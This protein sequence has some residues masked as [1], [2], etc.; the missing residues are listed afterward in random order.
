MKFLHFPSRNLVIP[1]LLLLFSIFA[2]NLSAQVQY[3]VTSNTDAGNPQGLNGDRDDRTNGWTLIISGPQSSNSWSTAVSLPFGF[4]VYGQ[5][6]TQCRA[7]QNGLLTFNTGSIGTPPGNNTSLPNALLPDLTLAV[8]WDDFTVSPPTTSQSDIYWRTYGTAPNR[9]F[10]VKWDRFEYSN[11]TWAYFAVVLEESSNKIYFLDYNYNDGGP[12][13]STIGVQLDAATAVQAGASPNYALNSGTRN[14]G[15]NDYFEFVPIAAPVSIPYSEDFSSCTWPSEWWQSS[16]G[17]TYR[18]T[19]SNSNNA[20]GAACE[21]RADDEPGTGNGSSILVMPPFN[22]TGVTQLEVLFN[23]FFDDQGSGMTFGLASSGDLVTWTPEWTA[24]SGGGDLGPEPISAIVTNNLGSVTYLAFFLQGNM[25]ND[26]NSWNIDDVVVQEYQPCLTIPY[27][28]DFDASPAWP[29]G[30]VTTDPSIWYIDTNW[31]GVAPPTGN[32]VYS[33]Y[34][35][36]GTGTV[37]SP[38]FDGSLN[39]NIH[40]RF[41]HYWRADWP[42]STQDGYFYGSPDGG[43]TVYLIDEWH[44][45]T[46]GSDEGW[47]EYDVSAWADGGSNILFAWVVDHNDDW[48]WIF[49][50]FQIQEGP[51][52]TP[53]LWTG[54]VN[55]DWSNTGNWSDLTIPT[56]T[57]DVVIPAGCPN[58]PVVD[59]TAHV[60]SIYIMDGAD[61]TVT[62]GADLTL[63]FNIVTGLSTGATLTIDDGVVNAVI[64]FV[65]DGSYGQLNG[66]SLNLS[67]DLYVGFGIGGEFELNGG[68]CSVT[69]N[70]YTTFNSTTD[71]N[72]GNLSFNNWY[73]S[74]SQVFSRG[75]VEISGGLI[76][77]AGSVAFG[78]FDFTGVMDGPAEMIIGGTYR[79]LETNWTHTNGTIYMTGTSG[80]GPHYFMSSVFGAGNNGSAYNLGILGEGLEFRSNPTG[81]ITGFRVFNNMSVFGGLVSTLADPGYMND[82]FI[83]NGHANVRPKGSMTMSVTGT[84]TIG[85]NLLIWSNDQGTG[86]W[87]DNGNTSVSGVTTVQRYITPDQWHY[88][89]PPV[90]NAVSGV[91][92][93]SYLRAWEEPNYSWGPYI[94]PTNIPLNVAEGYELWK[95]GTP[96]TFNYTGGIL[97]TGN[98]AA[99]VTATDRNNNGGIYWGDYEGWNFIGNPY[100]SALDWNGSWVSSNIDPTVYIWD[101]DIGQ[102]AEWNWFTGL[103]VNKTDGIVPANQGFFVKANDFNPSIVIPQSQRL[104][105]TMDF[106]KN[107][108]IPSGKPLEAGIQDSPDEMV[109]RSYGVIPVKVNKPGPELSIENATEEI[110]GESQL[111]GG[112][113]F[114]N[115]LRLSVSGNGYTDEAIVMF[116]IDAT[117]SFDNMFDAFKLT[118]ISAAPQ[119]YSY[120][121]GEKMAMNCFPLVSGVKIVPLGLTVGAD[122]TYTLSAADIDSFIEGYHIYLEDTWAG[123]LINLKYQPV[124]Q[125]F[126]S[127]FDGPDRFRLHFAF[128]DVPSQE[129]FKGTGQDNTLSVYS[130]GNSIYVKTGNEFRGTLYVYNMMG[131]EIMHQAVEGAFSKFEVQAGEGAYI[132][133]LVG[134]GIINTSK[135]YFE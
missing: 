11:Y 49:D 99:N 38:C 63:N 43:T 30:W 81:N 62:T 103:G 32:H 40:V 109:A 78:G 2:L 29:A 75:N 74:P 85:G 111:K 13:T 3:A 118:G 15:D 42:F 113:F 107:S 128:E 52:G 21:M 84:S 122:A 76:N 61:F 106:Y 121:S 34:L 47:K 80:A 68:V 79:N 12:G 28:Q 126:A 60:N 18:W 110:A 41:Y 17:C 51:W 130:Y 53:G 70:L 129:E 23:H 132:V 1:V 72:S 86:S 87:I 67:G 104:H 115:H 125:F 88:V 5:A 37:Y 119:L 69:G 135:V 58:Y 48:Y 9:Q 16:V 112:T 36:V 82:N 97:N 131:Q 108:I 71:I 39:S 93:G 50:D 133:K 100:P 92:L 127:P 22:T 6:V 114:P 33:D 46:P 89:S 95:T 14:V 8:F 31:P 54:L 7:S 124:Y 64:L 90:S 73:R 59:E 134:S 98:I 56:S 102:Y 57:I 65:L 101:G 25:N 44:H 117:D 120:I 123:Q 20:G 66:G 10:W 77:A 83:I 26:F 55:T 27:S 24:S 94:V 45:N 116:H 19:V 96:K 91:F 105:S 35:V 4:E